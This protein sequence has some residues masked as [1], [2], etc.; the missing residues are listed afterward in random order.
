MNLTETGRRRVSLLTVAAM[1]GA[2][3]VWTAAAPPAPATAAGETIISTFYV[4]LFEDNAREALVSVNS[5]TGTAL[6][7]TT[8]ITVGAEGA[9]I[10]YDHWEDAY[11]AAP[12]LEVQPSTLVFGD[13]NTGNGNAAT[14]CVQ[15]GCAGDLLPS[16]AVL[17]LNNSG[18]IVPGSL[19]T[20]RNPATAVFD[21]RDKISS[22]DGLAVTH[23]TWPTGINALHSEMAAA[24]DTSR[25]GVNFS[26]P[27]GEDTPLQGTADTFGYTSI[28]VMAR[29]ANTLVSID[30]NNDGDFLDGADINQTIGEGQTVF[31][32][33]NVA[34][35]TRIVTGKPTQVF[36][37]TGWP[38]SNY[39]NRS[40]QVFPTEGL[41]NDYVA[42]ASTAR[43]D[44]TYAT[45]LYL[46]N[47]QDIGITV[48]VTTPT[49]SV[50][51]PIPARETLDPA[52][53][54]APGDAARITSSATFAAVAGSG[55]REAGGNS[56]NYD[57]GYSLLPARVFANGAFDQ[58]STSVN[59]LLHVT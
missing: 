56:K 15:V 48:T 35:G 21:G 43:A 2:A 31:V 8:S 17:R 39:E 51:Y 28:E 58:S 23:A 3:L 24:F 59:G 13:G 11:E 1:L 19:S 22:T 40:F 55:T 50:S 9:I 30:M 20:P 7:S 37:M 33:G 10:Y 6:S 16:G 25:W 5:G 34:Q 46:F 36:L 27:V 57:W 14:Y 42:P 18:T 32:D 54:L 49:G 53:F 44:G 45:V 52:P 29:E 12:N 26:V 41:V 4:P 47:P 38:T